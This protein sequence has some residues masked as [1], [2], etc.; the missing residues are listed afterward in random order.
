MKLACVGCGADLAANATFCNQC[1][2]PVDADHDGV[3]DGLGRLIEEKAREIVADERR[4]EQAEKDRQL[5]LAEL[6][7]MTVREAA[8]EVNLR[9]NAATPRAAVPLFLH[10]L[11]W[12][13]LAIFALWI[14]FGFAPHAILSLVGYSPAGVVLC[15]LQCPECSGPGRS[16]MSNYK[17]SWHSEKGR[18]GQA[19]LCHNP[20]YDADKLDYSK[21]RGE[22]NDELQPYLV[23]GFLGVLLRRGGHVRGWYRA[24]RRAAPHRQ[25]APIARRGAH[26]PRGGAAVAAGEARAVDRQ[27]RV[28]P[29]RLIAGATYPAAGEATAF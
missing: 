9:D 18:M 14:P 29:R 25:Q 19:L 2:R 17:G 10:I 27:R 23:H 12:W 13:A 22:L 16:F 11:R 24:A 7:A 28:V 8:I 4:K 20:K 5:E 3:P 1:G 26:H 15:P 21:I 6:Q